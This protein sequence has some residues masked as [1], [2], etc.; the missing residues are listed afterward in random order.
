[1][2]VR[3]PF[4]R[5][6]VPCALSLIAMGPARAQTVDENN[7]WNNTIITSIGENGSDYYA[8]SF[9]ADVSVI[10]KFGVVI[11]QIAPEGQIR[12]AIAADNGSGVP[13]FAAPLYVGP[14]VDP[15]TTPAWYY[16]TGLHIPVHPGRKYYVLLDGYDNPGATGYSGIGR[17]STQPIAGEGLIWSNNGG[18]GSWDADASYTI[19]IY[20]EGVGRAAQQVPALSGRMLV[21]LAAAL[22]GAGLFRLRS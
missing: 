11:Q 9:I 17:S 12:M 4:R 16:E 20:V 21:L 19:A 8:Q 14:L 1:M 7:G 18:V 6:L 13:D 2:R 15:T 3:S 22:A 10:T 5:A